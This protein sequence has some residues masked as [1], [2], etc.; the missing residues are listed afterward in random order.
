MSISSLIIGESGSGKTTSLRNIDPDNTLLIQVIKKPLPFRSEKWKTKADEKKKILVSDDSGTICNAMSKTS[1]QIVIIDDFQ[2]L[3]ANEFMY[4]ATETGFSKFSEIARHAWDVIRHSSALDDNK[5]VYFLSHSE[6]TEQ[7]RTKAKTIGKLLD[8][9]ITV[10]GLFTIVLRS[11]VTD[12]GYM[13]S[14]RNSGA[15]TVKAPADL[16]DADEID[17]DLNAVDDRIVDYYTLTK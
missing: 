6:T 11:I 7:G 3:M 14:T 2:Y 16:F 10:E 9:K 13:F 8:E 5:R 15:D 17:N 1:K 4:R 12:R